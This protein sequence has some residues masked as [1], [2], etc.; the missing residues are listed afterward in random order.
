MML[1]AFAEEIR[2][3]GRITSE[4]GKPVPGA[5][6]TLRSASGAVHGISDPTG[7]F[8]I[9][10]P[11]AGA[12]ELE[13][14]REGYFRLTRPKL[15]LAAGVNEAHL[16]L[17][18]LR[19]VVES[20]DVTVAAGGVD[21]DR[22]T[23]QQ[24]LTGTDI[25][26]VPYPSTNTL[27]NAFRAM[28]GVVED[29]RGGVHLHGGSEEQTLYT[30]EGFQLNDPLTGRFETRLSV[31]AVQ[32]LETTPGRPRAEYGK[33]SAGVLAIRSRTGDDKLRYSA[34]NFVPGIEHQKGLLIGGWTPRANI[35][36]P[37]KSGRAWFS[38][39]MDLQYIQ[40]VVPELPRGED[41]NRSWRGSNLLHNQVNLT[42]SNILTV[43]SL[44]NFYF[45]PRTGLTVL[46]PPESTVDR[47]SRQYF[48][49]IKDQI[50]FKR[51][52][53]VE[54]GYSNNRTFGREIP[55]GD[56]LYIVTP[57]G[58]YGN[59][60][61]DAVRKAGRD[62]WIVNAFL[63]VF[64]LLGEH[65]FKTG[66]D[67]DR[68]SYWQDVRRNG[69]E[70][71]TVDL[72]PQRR[73]FFQGS[74]RV[75]TSNFEASTYVQDSWRL[76]PNLLIEMG[77]RTD[78]DRLLRNWNFSPRFGFAWM[79]F[80]L[81]RTKFYGGFARIFDAT[82]LRIF[83]RPFDQYSLSTYFDPDGKFLRGP[84]LSIY[85]IENPNLASPR[86]HNWNFGVEQQWP[87]SVQ[88]RLNL[89]TRRGSRGLTFVNSLA[90][91]CIDVPEIFNG[92]TNPLF[93]AIYNLSGER[94]DRYSAVEMTIRRPFRQKYEFMLSYTRSRARSNAV[95]DQSIDEPLLVDNN[96]G[97]LPWDTPNRW[98][99]WG[100]LPTWWP[101][102]SVA[103]LAEY[104]S[105]FPFSVQDTNGQVIGRLNELRYPVFFELNLFLER[106]VGFRKNWWAVRFGFN[107]ITNHKN[108]NVVN[109][110]AGSPNFLRTFG[111]QSR[112]FNVRVR[113]LG[114]M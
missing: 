37:W 65:Q 89:V 107:N 38:N 45:A 83:T 16:I 31:E 109:N 17:E 21:M 52:A 53:L 35:S 10:A 49:Y 77:A 5:R 88:M 85:R 58:R 55:Q 47:R 9:E 63:P 67:L 105:G 112:A 75:G 114:K 104:R 91:A 101:K 12:Y 68:L 69:I 60:F 100:F 42:A 13:V 11:H 44:V 59:S 76:K 51:G 113:W 74:G 73:T 3:S 79:P 103:Y 108:P 72:V 29:G 64:P 90:C 94:S 71:A 57:F 106:R 62:Q 46:N 61:I 80:G 4:T 78:W 98:V 24:T 40:H 41:R 23:P 7:G 15:E 20:I 102:W 66:L 2:L 33:G 81:E 28:P 22:T 110:V 14:D 86:Y 30:L 48:T 82:S 1:H 93:D 39:S 43:G 25:L 97:P 8:Q 32:S 111:G 70:F 99:S 26:N 6:I 34:T 50:Y 87:H 19:E 27:R 96:S 36:G 92:I 54:L 84:A 56:A 18:T 95:V